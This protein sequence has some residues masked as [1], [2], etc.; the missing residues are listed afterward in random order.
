[1]VDKNKLIKKYFDHSRELTVKKIR[2]LDQF[3]TFFDWLI[4]SDD[5]KKDKTTEL[6]TGIIPQKKKQKAVIVS[7]E[8]GLLAGAEEITFFLKRRSDLKLYWYKEDREKIRP[9]TKIIEIEG[10]GSEILAFERTILNV[11]QHMSGIATHTR[12]LLSLIGVNTKL[13]A[14]RK[15]QWGWL[16]KKA[17]VVGGGL[18]H[19]LSLSNEIL[20]KDNHFNLL[21]SNREIAI[22]Q[23]VGKL[24]GK[25]IEIEVESYDE[26]VFFK[27]I[28][29]ELYP[30]KPFI[31]MLDNFSVSEVKRTMKKFTKDNV[32]VELS[33]G[34]T[35]KNLKSFSRLGADII[36]LGSLTNA[37]KSLDM[38]LT[39]V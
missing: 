6:I 14:T 31:I 36:S 4:Q 20:V 18:T 26:A 27:K 21:S 30:K 22:K 28:W 8:A 32:I 23:I 24:K 3:M 37:P 33:G 2:Y 9:G 12:Q 16:D 38:S 7:K 39:I 35:E 34:I 19:R 17:V 10:S 5:I 13:A 25:F 29:W 11:L 15:T 1:M